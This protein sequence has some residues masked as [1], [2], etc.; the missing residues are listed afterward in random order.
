M[1]V[2]SISK[3][4]ISLR[5]G[6][7]DQEAQLVH[8][9]YAAALEERSWQDVLQDTVRLFHASSAQMFTTFVPVSEG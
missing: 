8:D 6:M 1:R 9:I 7:V 5:V 4:G 2:L 3:A